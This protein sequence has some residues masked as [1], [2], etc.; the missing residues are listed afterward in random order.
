MMATIAVK[1]KKRGVAKKHPFLHFTDVFICKFGKF[2]VLL[3]SNLKKNTTMETDSVQQA[4]SQVT[5]TMTPK[6]RHFQAVGLLTL[7]IKLIIEA[8]QASKEKKN[9]SSQSSLDAKE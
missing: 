8:V 6:E 5:S 2:V 1:E 4:V 9:N 7:I 3:H